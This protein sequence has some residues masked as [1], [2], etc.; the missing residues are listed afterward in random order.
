MSDLNDKLGK[1]VDKY[2][3]NGTSGYNCAATTLL[4]LSEHFGIRNDLIPAVA[5][6]FGG[7]YADTHR[8]VCG[9]LSG[10][11]MAIGIMKKD[12]PHELGQEMLAHVKD[13]FGSWNC[14]DILDIDFDDE[15]QVNR[16]K[17]PKRISICTP[18]L[19]DLCVWLAERL[20]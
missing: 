8:S 19:K 18:L 3:W 10:G 5:Q 17:D 9:A 4:V 13:K 11:L 16:E 12:K 1:L 6:A 20:K 7:G 2:F 15:Q 14:D